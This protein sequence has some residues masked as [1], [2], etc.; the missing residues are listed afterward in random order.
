MLPEAIH[1]FQVIFGAMKN[2]TAKNEKLRI[3]AR[4]VKKE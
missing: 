1:A 3:I 4:F 2:S